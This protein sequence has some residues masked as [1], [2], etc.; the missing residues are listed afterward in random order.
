MI[1]TPVGKTV[2]SDA[3]PYSL[4]TSTMGCEGTTM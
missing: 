1:L 3:T 4:G 2:C